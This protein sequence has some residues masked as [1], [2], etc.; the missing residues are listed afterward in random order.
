MNRFQELATQMSKVILERETM[1][2]L[3]EAML[4]KML[5]NSKLDSKLAL[6]KKKT[7]S[8]AAK[9]LKKQEQIAKST[10]AKTKEFKDHMNSLY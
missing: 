1:H 2:K 8:M 10:I 5:V 6:E 4:E 9:L 3:Q 7:Q